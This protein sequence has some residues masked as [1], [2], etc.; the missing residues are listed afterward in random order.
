MPIRIPTILNTINTKASDRN[1]MNRS[2]LSKYEYIARTM[3][4]IEMDIAR[5][6]PRVVLFLLI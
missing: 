3:K 2:D 4:N 1:N 6:M 5:P